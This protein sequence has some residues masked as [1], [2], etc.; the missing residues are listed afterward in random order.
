[1]SGIIRGDPIQSLPIDNTPPSE[2]QMKMVN[3]LFEHNPRMV[4]RI[5]HQMK[6]GLIIASLFVLFSLPVVDDM[7]KKFIPSA[8]NS[9]VLMGFKAL[10]VVLIYFFIKN[11]H[12]SRK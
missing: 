12:L 1:M 5:A 10:C 2:N 8:E 4:D 9:L 6:D 3:T 7:I 11:I